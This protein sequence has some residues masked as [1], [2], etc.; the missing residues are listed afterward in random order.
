MAD[1]Q[2]PVAPIWDDVKTFPRTL[3]AEEGG[4]D[5]IYGGFPC[6]DISVAG[7]GGGLEGERSGLFYELCRVAKEVRPAFVF[8]ENVPAIRTRGLGRVLTE[9]TNMGYDC[10]WTCVS[11]AEV[12]ALHLRK[13]WFLLA[14]SN[15]KRLEGSEEARD[16]SEG[17]KK[18]EQQSTGLPEASLWNTRMSPTDLREADGSPFR[19]DRIKAAGNGVVP[20]QAKEAFKRLMGLK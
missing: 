20:Q 10:R 1:G 3:F 2:L 5:I 16:I 4:V 13:R 7:P 19:L 11:A 14:H 15:S 8:L 12:G 17:R 9:L 18:T 6:Q